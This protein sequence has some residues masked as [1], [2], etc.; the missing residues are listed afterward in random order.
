MNFVERL[1]VLSSGPRISAADVERESKRPAG[2][3]GLALAGG[4]AP[5][6]K[7]ESSVIE[8]GAAIL[9][10]E[11]HALEKAL[12]SAKGNRAVAARLL[13]ISVRSLYYKLEQHQ[14]S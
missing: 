6:A 11:R 10:A 7:Q 14:I 8:L 1:V 9:K 4:D 5:A 13:G 3:M 2:A 12:R